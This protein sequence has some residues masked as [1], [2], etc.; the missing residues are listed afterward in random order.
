[1]ATIGC[2]RE[3]K[4]K[5]VVTHINSHFDA[6]TLRNSRLDEPQESCWCRFH[7]SSTNCSI[8]SVYRSYIS[9][10][11]LEEN[12]LQEILCTRWWKDW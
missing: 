1:M 3:Y 10:D 2:D 4:V 7:V 9:N 5:V 6:I 11:K 8:V 12:I